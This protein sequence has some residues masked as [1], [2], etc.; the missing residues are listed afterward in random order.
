MI[1]QKEARTLMDHPVEAG[2]HVLSVY[3]NVDPSKGWNW[4][5]SFK[6]VVKNMF[7]DIEQ[8]LD[9]QYREEFNQDAKRVM[10]FLSDFKLKGR[11]LVLFAV[12]SSGGPAR[13]RLRAAGKW[14][15]HEQL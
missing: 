12:G 4:D 2:S 9:D 6:T 7:H 5:T 14:Q 15:R 3:L 11:G 10:E 1:S 8:G 13:R